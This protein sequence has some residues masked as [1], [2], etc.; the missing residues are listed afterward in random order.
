MKLPYADEGP[1]PIEQADRI[2]C[3]VLGIFGNDDQGPSPEDVNDYEAALNAAGVTNQIHRYDG[4]GHG[5]QDHTNEGRYRKEQSEDAWE[6]SL[7]FFSR[8]LA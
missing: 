2:S 4:A 3:P 1:A 8:C 5:F 6:K 7:D